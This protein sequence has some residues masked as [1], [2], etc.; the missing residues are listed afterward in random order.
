MR[1]G[2]FIDTENFGGAE[3]ILISTLAYLRKCGHEVVVYSFGNPAL[4]SACLAH[5]AEIRMAPLRHR[6]KSASGLPSFAW[7]FSKVLRQDG[8]EIL[9]SHLFGPIVGGGAACWLARVPHIGTLH[10]VYIVQERP[11]RAKLLTLV[12]M[13]GTK[14]VCVSEQMRDYY[15]AAS[16]I[17]PSRL[18]VVRNGVDIESFA[19]ERNRADTA[20][21]V[22]IIMVGRLHPIK[23]H[24]LMIRALAS[25]T[26]LRT[27]RL[28]ILGDGPMLAALEELCNVLG[29]SDRVEFL[30][31]R[32]DV[33]VQLG[34][35]DIFGLVSDSEGMSLSLIEALASGLPIIATDVGNNA[36]LVV[37]GRNGFLIPAGDPD[38]LA[39][40]LRTLIEDPAMRRRFGDSSSAFAGESLEIGSMLKAY[41]SMYEAGLADHRIR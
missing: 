1:I 37:N 34:T 23:R 16:M 25:L 11:L 39:A 14:L 19:R 40:A 26:S 33:A 3:S 2:L 8:I 12:N 21:S 10:D 6:Y 29:I 13:L 17:R 30:G 4:E 18:T 35:A 5:G 27:W 32:H 15:S 28:R 7:A 22:T 41:Q 38:A 36:E 24:D 31:R 20:A 9:H